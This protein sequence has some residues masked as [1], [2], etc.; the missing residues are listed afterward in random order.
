MPVFFWTDILIFFLIA[1]A[2]GFALYASGKE[3]LRLPWR[4]VGRSPVAMS[5]L[6]VLAV[7]VVIGVLDSIHYKPALDS[8]D[9]NGKTQYS[10]EVLS[11]FDRLDYRVCVNGRRKPTRRRLRSICS[12]RKWWSCPMA[13][14]SATSRAW[15]TA[16]LTWR[17]PGKSSVILPGLRSGL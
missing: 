15:S 5:A 11:L 12:A 2:V 13:H 10:S 1:L 8:G 16:A 3:H 17:T 4:E 9:G 14:N 6:V 7:Y